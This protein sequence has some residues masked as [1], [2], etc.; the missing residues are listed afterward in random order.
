MQYPNHPEKLNSKPAFSGRDM[1]AY[2][3]KM[4]KVP[5]ASPPEA[6]LLCLWKD[7]PERLRRKHPFKKAGRFLGDLYSLNRTQGRIFVV[8]NFG[9]GAPAVAAVA[10]EMIAWGV[11]R[12]ISIGWAAGI[13]VDLHPAD[14]VV[15]EKA[16]RDE[17]TS[18]HYL[19][20]DKFVNADPQL[21]S[22]L[23]NEVS[24]AGVRVQ[25]GATWTTDAPYRE[26]EVEIRQ[27]QLEGIKTVEMEAAALFAVAQTHD[28]QA[29]SALVVADSLA[30]LEW[31]TP[32]EM[33]IAERSLEFVYGAAIRA[34]D[35]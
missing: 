16:M 26:T 11:R 7:L 28:V 3:R 35:K 25:I 12:I 1:L 14:I 2:R 21:V 8:T 6:A 22:R 5:N 32:G 27:Y 34:L 17:G 29:T 4:G 10:E 20:P 31:R 9:I 30:N 15:C 23:M 18:Y 13:Q 24:N 19:P 33:K